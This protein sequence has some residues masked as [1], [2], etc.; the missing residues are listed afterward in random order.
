M[1]S[2]LVPQPFRRQTHG[3]GRPKKGKAKAKAKARA[4]VPDGDEPLE[5]D[6]AS[7]NVA[8]RMIFLGFS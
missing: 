3:M 2:T 8:F 5:G 6:E 1:A 7:E 4:D